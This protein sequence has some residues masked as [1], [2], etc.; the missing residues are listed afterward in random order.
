M[1]KEIILYNLKKSVSEEDYKK[2]CEEYKG[3]L[4]TGLDGSKS[5]TLV[6][7]LGSMGGDG[8]KFKP[9]E[10]IE[11]PYKYIGL[12]DIEDLDVW[13]KSQE[14]YEFKQDFSPQWFTNW[15]SDFVILQGVEIYFKESD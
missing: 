8:E 5:F 10:E 12:M 14:S 3:P 4:L 11:P 2:W 1:A 6:K 9:P 15:V 7:A 13:H